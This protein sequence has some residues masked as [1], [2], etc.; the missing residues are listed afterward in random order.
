MCKRARLSVGQSGA[1]REDGDATCLVDQGIQGNF[2]VA[3]FA[4]S[5]FALARQAQ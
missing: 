2:Y 1:S 5:I 3:N 4:L